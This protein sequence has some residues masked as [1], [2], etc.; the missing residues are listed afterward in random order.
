MH[1]TRDPITSTAAMTTPKLHG[2]RIEKK[3]KIKEYREK[4]AKYD[5][6]AWLK[7]NI[8]QQKYP[9]DEIVQHIHQKHPEKDC[10]TYSCWTCGIKFRKETAMKHHVKTVKH[11]L[12][13]KKYTIRDESR[14]TEVIL[15]EAD[16]LNE[17]QTENILHI[18]TI[19]AT[20]EQT[21]ELI[22]TSEMASDI[23]PII[24]LNTVADQTN[25]T[26]CTDKQEVRTADPNEAKKIE[27]V[28][29]NLLKAINANQDQNIEYEKNKIITQYYQDDEIVD[30]EIDDW[31]IM[32]QW[33]ETPAIE[34]MI[35]IDFEN[36]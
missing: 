33:G 6:I 26:E 36:L 22:V 14:K 32:D 17:I 4:Q 1:I 13:A 9:N 8:C 2:Y 15:I 24:R 28:V 29:R 30:L 20:T 19:E 23:G 5:P 10:S 16:L 7:C 3:M 21:N 25:T 31:L 12:E 18:P 11:Q 34:E 35:P 27:D